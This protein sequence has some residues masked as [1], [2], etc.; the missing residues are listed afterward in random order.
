[1]DHVSFL[2]FPKNI[3]EM[4]KKRALESFF[5]PAS[6]K[7]ARSDRAPSDS[8]VL[9]PTCQQAADHPTSTHSTY[10]FP[11]PHLP[12]HI[13]AALSDVPASEGQQINDQPD[14]DLLYFQPFIPPEVENE[15]F[16][17][18][19]KELFFYR[20]KYKIKRGGFE[21]DINTPR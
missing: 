18:L 3:F 1:M 15:L 9:T 20:V 14:L 6:Q 5:T 4:S 7:K 21:T 16:R 17:F 13:Q 11:V 2:I 12:P 19:R 10:P 8:T